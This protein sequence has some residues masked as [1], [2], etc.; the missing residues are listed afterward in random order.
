[1]R[2]PIAYQHFLKSQNKNLI[3]E[4]KNKQQKKHLLPSSQCKKNSNKNS[5]QRY[6][7]PPYV[8]RLTNDE[9]LADKLFSNNTNN[10]Q[11]KEMKNSFISKTDKGENQ[12]IMTNETYQKIYGPIL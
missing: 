12:H 1:M 2:D 6:D 5:Q 9:I 4:D 10:K 8:R 11:T 3:E 7:G